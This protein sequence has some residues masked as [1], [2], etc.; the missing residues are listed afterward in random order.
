M[1]NSADPS[2]APVVLPSREDAFVRASSEVIGGP[3]GRRVHPA[4]GWWTPLRVMLALCVL[5]GALAFIVKEPCREDAWTQGDQYRHACYSDVP[6]LYTLRGLERGAVPYLDSKGADVV[7]YPVLTGLAMWITAKIV[8][9]V[10]TSGNPLER[11]RRYFDVN[12]LLFTGLLMLT[13]A[14]TVQLVGR[15]PWDAAMIPLAPGLILAG[16]INWDM[17][18]VALATGG[19]L[20]W[21]RK[22]PLLAGVLFGLGAAAKLYPLFIIGPL[23][24]LCLREKR[25]REWTV[26]FAAGAAAWLV[27]NIPIA[28][29]APDAWW[30]FY[31]LSRERPASFGSIW[32]SLSRHGHAVP[33]DKLNLVA[34]GL[35]VA[36]CVGIAV[37]AWKAPRRPRVGQLT[38]LVVAAFLLTNK[39]Y[40]PQYVV[41]LV[42]LYPLARPRWSEFLIW[43]AAE[44]AY[45]FAAWLHIEGLNRPELVI[46]DWP[47]DLATVLR[48]AAELWICALIVRDIVRVDTDPVRNDGLPGEVDDP[49]GGVLIEAQPQPH[50]HAQPLPA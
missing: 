9:A 20:A 16:T 13:T 34:G 19:L 42:A 31:K 37:L 33:P 39:V 29:A 7:E 49:V 14:M 2:F 15:R 23:L 18:A 38:F 10:D 3:A 1:A 35:F 48:M 30:T 11:T 47:H 40:S 4:S 46:P 43:Q 36:L 41:W 21:A 5:A 28:K 50:R 17:V 8:D 27:V 6:N 24:I 44:V 25:L 26:M 12:V 32:Y 45:F 22:K